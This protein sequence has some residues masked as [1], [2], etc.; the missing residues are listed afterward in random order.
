MTLPWCPFILF[1]Y[2]AFMIMISPTSFAHT[3]SLLNAN[4]AAVNL[5]GNWSN[6]RFRPLISQILMNEPTVTNLVILVFVLIKQQ[7]S[8]GVLSTLL[9]QMILLAYQSYTHKELY[10]S[11]PIVNNNVPSWLNFRLLTPFLWNPRISIRV[12]LVSTSHRLISSPHVPETTI[13]P[14][15][16]SA[17]QFIYWV[18]P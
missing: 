2:L 3:N 17:K 9:L 10:V 7:S 12:N 5:P 13:Y 18:C 4:V 16:C 6:D 15:G 14:F 8:T 1:V 11:V